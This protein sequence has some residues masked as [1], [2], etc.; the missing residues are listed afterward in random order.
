MSREHLVPGSTGMLSE[1][2]MEM[3]TGASFKRFSRANSG[4]VGAVN[5]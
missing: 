5:E 3:D 4:T 2:V 1:W